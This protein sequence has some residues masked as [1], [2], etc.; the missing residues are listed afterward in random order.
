[1]GKGLVISSMC[2]NQYVISDKGEV[3]GKVFPVFN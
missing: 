2:G 3:K 1:M